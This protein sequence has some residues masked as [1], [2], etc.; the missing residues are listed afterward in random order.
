MPT[1]GAE[2]CFAEDGGTVEMVLTLLPEISMLM[3]Q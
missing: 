3:L 2:T 1:V